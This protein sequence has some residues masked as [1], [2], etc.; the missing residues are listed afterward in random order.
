[1]CILPARAPTWGRLSGD[2]LSHAFVESMSTS[3]RVQQQNCWVTGLT[4]RSGPRGLSASGQ[5][6][7]VSLPWVPV[8][9]GRAAA[10]Q[11]MCPSRG[12]SSRFSP[13]SAGGLQAESPSTQQD[14]TAGLPTGSGDSSAPVPAVVALVSVFTS[15][16]SHSHSSSTWVCC[17]DQT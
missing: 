16:S 7:L 1:M 17:A 2:T 8:L 11:P 3:Y 10:A 13:D 12:P 4:P 14:L 15:A 9:G 5:H 6:L